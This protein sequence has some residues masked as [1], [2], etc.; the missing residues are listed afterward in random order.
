MHSVNQ[1]FGEGP[2][3]TKLHKS[4]TAIKYPRPTRVKNKTSAPTQASAPL[5]SSLPITTPV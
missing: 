1:D 5:P 3:G 4:A 2:L